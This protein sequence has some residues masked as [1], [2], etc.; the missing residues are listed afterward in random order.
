MLI[1]S[2]LQPI[3]LKY[4]V[5]S[6]GKFLLKAN[7]HTFFYPIN[8]LQSNKKLYQNFHILFSFKFNLLFQWYLLLLSVLN[9]EISLVIEIESSLKNFFKSNN[10]LIQLIYWTFLTKNIFKTCQ[11]HS[12]FHQTLQGLWRF[13]EVFF[14]KMPLR[15]KILHKSGKS[16][17]N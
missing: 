2:L 13:F 17:T 10:W 8:T 5:F 6:I 7:Q 12:L 9:I 4:C 15:L 3:K 11:F 14:F 16:L 1:K